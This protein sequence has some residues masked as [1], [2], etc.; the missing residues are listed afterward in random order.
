MIKD[1]FYY[2]NGVSDSETFED[3]SER[4]RQ[5]N[6]RQIFADFGLH[7]DKKE[8][9]QL[10]EM[11]ERIDSPRQSRF[12]CGQRKCIVCSQHFYGAEDICSPCMK[13]YREEGLFWKQGE[14]HED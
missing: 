11:F 6:R 7:P 4:F 14:V 12:N 10:R 13:I 3:D 9:A 1:T 5:I 8:Y 2:G